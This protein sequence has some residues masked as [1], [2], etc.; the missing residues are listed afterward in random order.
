MVTTSRLS[1]YNEATDGIL[2]VFDGMFS[3]QQSKLLTALFYIN[4]E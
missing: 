4:D 3:K 1:E 2:A